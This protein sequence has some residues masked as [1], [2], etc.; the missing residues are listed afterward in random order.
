MVIEHYVQEK[1]DLAERELLAVPGAQ[2]APRF[3]KAESISSLARIQPACVI[4]FFEA[5]NWPPAKLERSCEVSLH[6]LPSIGRI[7][8]LE[9]SLYWFISAAT[10]TYLLFEIVTA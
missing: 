4:D 8:R 3:D 9:E 6:Q 1:I 10:L 5:A 2:S 7:D